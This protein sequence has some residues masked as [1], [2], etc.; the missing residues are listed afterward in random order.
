MKDYFSFNFDVI[1]QKNLPYIDNIVQLKSK[2]SQYCDVDL[3]LYSIKD[4][5]CYM[6]WIH[7]PEGK[8]K[9][10]KLKSL[11]FFCQMYHSKKLFWKIIG[12][13]FIN[14][15]IKK[16]TLKLFLN[17]YLSKNYCI[18][19]K[20]P[21]EYFLNLREIKL[22][23]IDLK[24]AYKTEE[25]LEYRYGKNWN[26]KDENYNQSG[27]WKKSKAIV[28]NKMNLIPFPEIIE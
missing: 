27:K 3:Y 7:K 6:R 15:R 24:I 22:Y 17:Y 2:N 20:F 26:K 16:Y 23:D 4:K 13:C 10:I 21:V 19:H 8:L 28:L 25:Y 18:Y 9:K 11:I 5:H 1:F 12:F 14:Q